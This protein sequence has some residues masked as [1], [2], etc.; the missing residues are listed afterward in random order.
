MN[1]EESSQGCAQRGA[2]ALRRNHGSLCQIEMSSAARQIRDDEGEKR[3][4]KSGAD[5]V[6]ALHGK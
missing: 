1:N 2:Y 3:A 5:A 6:E 4:I